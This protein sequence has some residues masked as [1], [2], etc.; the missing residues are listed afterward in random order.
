[1]V[2]QKERKL[3]LGSCQTHDKRCSGVAA[4]DVVMQDPIF[5][6]CDP[7]SLYLK[8]AIIALFC[9]SVMGRKEDE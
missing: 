1:M 7:A 5:Q 4:F 3:G 2:S 6:T 9:A 8:I